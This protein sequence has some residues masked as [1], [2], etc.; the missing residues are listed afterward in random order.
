MSSTNAPRPVESA[1]VLDHWVGGRLLPSTGTRTQ[2]VFNPATGQCIREVSLGT[3]QDLNAAVGA[4]LKVQP[5]WAD[6]PPIRRAACCWN[7]CTS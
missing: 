4:A 2:P 3:E 1:T 5:S 6:T 7:F